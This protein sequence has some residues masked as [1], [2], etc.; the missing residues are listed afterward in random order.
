MIGR[1]IVARKVKEIGDG[2]M[3]RNEM[4]EVFG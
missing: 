4:L 3:N 1:N 2:V